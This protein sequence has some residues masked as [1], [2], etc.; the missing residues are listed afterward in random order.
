MS[1]FVFVFVSVFDNV[2]NHV[3][4]LVS[5]QCVDHTYLFAVVFVLI[6]VCL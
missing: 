3:V 1:V 4:S 2:F 5:V 6:H